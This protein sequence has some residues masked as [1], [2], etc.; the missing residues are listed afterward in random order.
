VLLGEAAFVLVTSVAI[1]LAVGIPMA[2]LFV[3]ILRRVFIVPPTSLSFPLSEVALLA[4][5]LVVT[6]GLAAAIISAAI[7]R[8]RLVEFLRAE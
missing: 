4:G 8:I 6:I 2:Y 1:G 5:L 7:R 3:Q